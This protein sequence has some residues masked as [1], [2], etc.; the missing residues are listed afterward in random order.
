MEITKNQR[1][2]L[3]TLAQ[4]IKPTVMIGKEGLSSAVISQTDAELKAHEL[5]KVKFVGH[6]DFKKEI[7]PLLAENTKSV[8]VRIIGH[9][10]VFYR[11]EEKE[12]DRKIILPHK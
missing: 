8:F 1:R 5:I 2:Y 3:S 12:E 10:A 9:N 4:K 11:P 7:A 6:K